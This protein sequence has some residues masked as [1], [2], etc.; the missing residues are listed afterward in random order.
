MKVRPH[1]QRGAYAVMCALLLV[2]ILGMLGLVFDL[3]MAY[4]RR[5]EMQS[6]VEGAALAAGRALDGTMA[7]VANAR[8]KARDRAE[9]NNYHFRTPIAWDDAALRFAAS[10]DAAD[11]DWVGAGGVSSANV[12]TMRYA[13]VDS[14]GLGEQS[15]TRVLFSRI[16]NT[17][18]TL[19]LNVHA[20]AG[21]SAVAVTP[22][23]ICAISNAPAAS[24]PNSLGAGNEE[25]LE[26]GFRRGVT[27]NLL[28]LNPNGTSPANY[29]VN[30]LDFPGAPNRA[31]HLS[32]AAVAPFVC[33]GTIA[34]PDLPAGAD[35]YV[36]APFPPS[37]ASELN[38]RFEQYAVNG[39]CSYLT[40]PPDGRNVRDFSVDYSGWWM[41][42]SPAPGRG[43]VQEATVAGALLTI[44][45]S[46]TTVAG[47]TP[48]SYGTLWSFAKAVRYSATAPGN[49][50]TAFGAADWNKLY[51]VA[52]GQ[53]TSSY[54]NAWP[55]PYAYGST[56]H[57]L[58]PSQAGIVGRRVLNIP[59]L[60]CPVSGGSA[61]VLAIGRFLMTTPATT[62]PAAVHG[63]FG[64]I[65]TDAAL[66]AAA[67]LYQ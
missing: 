17:S 62:A 61:T 40:A 11:S 37:L 56:P 1:R 25:L 24:R 36:R 3:S 26:Y 44:G 29:L 48:A 50:G 13:R 49:A 22:L 19:N 12:A 67:S 34:R 21:R 20:V 63:E 33:S 5:A 6:V 41:T 59:L 7:G 64:G 51:Q 65:A 10:P 58:A 28:K 38:S 23:A 43:S 9:D 31:S 30:P 53:L 18:G 35:V 52:S 8:L 14:S 66:G 47:T 55:R 42:S 4:A 54:S 15:D 27:Y 16:L 32:D 2:V 57:Y 39:G 46:P 45:E 60:A